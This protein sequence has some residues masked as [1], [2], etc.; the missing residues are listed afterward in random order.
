MN[1]ATHTP[2]QEDLLDPDALPDYQVTNHREIQKLLRGIAD[3]RALL[4][5]H[6]DGGPL[7][8]VTT[9]LDLTTD[10]EG[11]ILDSSRDERIMERI[12]RAESVVCTGRIDG[13]RMQFT[14]EDPQEFPYDGFLALRCDLPSMVLRVQRRE[15]F[16]LP[17]PMSSPLECKLILPDGDGRTHT[18][19][20]R[21]VDIS[22]EGIGLMIMDRAEHVGTGQVVESEL[23]V[24]EVG[25]V[26][27]S[28][29]VRNVFER[30]HRGTLTLRAGFQLLDPPARV[31]TALQRYIFKVERERRFLEVD[32]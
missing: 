18:T 2:V 16:R 17:V 25:V 23:N 27:V 11:L 6:I 15:S 20:V 28:L 12:E 13:V 9:V 22:S 4:A 31:V 3:K 8:F 24:P 30:S 5:G 1:D 29:Q 21:V 14:A 32:R 10:G 26:R 19:P 7:T